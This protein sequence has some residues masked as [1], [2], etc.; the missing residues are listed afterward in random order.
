MSGLRRVVE[1]ALTTPWAILPD[2]LG[3]I[4]DVIAFQSAGGSLTAEEIRARIGETDKRMPSQGAGVAVLP[5]HGVV[6]HRM[7]QMDDISGGIS[8]EKFAGWFRAAMSDPAVGAIVLDI[9]SPGGT[10]AGVQELA[11]LI[12]AARGQKPVVAIANAMAASAA[13]WIASAAEEV[14]VTPSGDVGSIGVFAMHRDLSKAMER[15][16]ISTTVIK[17][18]KFK[19]EGL[20]HE[21]LSAEARE[22]MQ[23]RVDA[24]FQTFLASVAR[25]RG[26]DTDR[27]ESHFGEGRLVSATK[28]KRAGMVDRVGTMDT[29]LGKLSGGGSKGKLRADALEPVI[30]MA[31]PATTGAMWITN[32]TVTGVSPVTSGFMRLTGQYPLPTTQDEDA[33]DGAGAS[34]R[35]ATPESAAEA[36]E[37]TM[38]ENGTEAATAVD[39]AVATAKQDRLRIDA[40]TALAADENIPASTLRTWITEGTTEAQAS[41]EVLNGLKA[42]RKAPIAPSISPLDGGDNGTKAGPFAS[43]GEQL[44]AIRQYQAGVTTPGT[45]KLLRVNEMLGAASGASAGVG[46]DGGFLIQT[47]YATDLMKEGRSESVLASRCSTTEISSDSDGLEVS[48]IDETSRATGSRWGGVQLYRAAEAD[49]VTASK[50]KIGKWELRLE[51]IRGLFYS[52]TRLDRDAS[53]LAQVVS[54]A[55]R[56]EFAFVIDDEIYSGNGVARCLGIT[57]APC[58]VS[59]AKETGQAAATIVA[60]N[61][62]NMWARALPRSKGRGIWVYNTECEVQLQQMQIGTGTSAQLVFMPPNGLSGSPFATIYGRPAIAIEQASALGT[63]GDIAFLDLDMYKLIT[64]GGIQEDQSPHVRFIYWENTWRWSVSINGAPKLKSAITPY[65]GTNT[66]SPFVTLATRA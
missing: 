48:Y 28:A 42:D 18:G 9:D 19:A 30:V 64:K 35:T 43:F 7:S 1:A 65:K 20:P 55:F 54:E 11:E 49:T 52:T 51:D 59:V 47:D 39:P 46:P 66:L 63:V 36:K 12:F 57:A 4:A 29:L 8:T 5:L 45:E 44:L 34:A 23:E 33:P 26:V 56:D 40:L 37:H 21:A 41:R 62:I 61:I 17:A 60:E 25:F 13:Y 22:A 3:T 16:G 38:P 6:G 32:E 15:E 27:V 31:S 2:K 14:W 10:V 50:P 24:M 53:A 58:T